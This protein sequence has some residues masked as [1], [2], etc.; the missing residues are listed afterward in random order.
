MDS[1]CIVHA[2]ALQ[3]MSLFIRIPDRV[4]E[5]VDSIVFAGRKVVKVHSVQWMLATRA[6]RF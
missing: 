5:E 6:V 2:H 4:R 1:F 3:G